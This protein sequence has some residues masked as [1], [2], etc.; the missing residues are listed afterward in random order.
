VAPR[1]VDRN[2]LKARVLTKAMANLAPLI[3]APVEGEQGKT[4]F[5]SPPL[6]LLFYHKPVFSVKGKS[7]QQ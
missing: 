4:I 1:E 7:E 3:R 2:R 5:F 6:L